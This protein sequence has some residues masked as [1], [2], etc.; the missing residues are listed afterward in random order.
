MKVDHANLSVQTAFTEA[1]GSDA[2]A[3]LAAGGNADAFALIMRRHNR[4]LFRT[5]RSIL[6]DDT[7]TE[8]ALQESYLRA[9]RG[10]ATFRADAKLSTWLVRIVVNES[11]GRLRRHRQLGAQ[12]IPLDAALAADTEDL[13]MTEATPQN[14]SEQPEQTKGVRVISLTTLETI[15]ADP[16]TFYKSYFFHVVRRRASSNTS[17]ADTS[18]DSPRSYTAIRVA[19]LDPTASTSVEVPSCSDQA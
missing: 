13:P 4:L 7:E 15:D 6:K 11:L 8:D 10:L 18:L 19:A 17:F 2:L 9:W 16:F 12:V 5:A 14:E 3:S 1:T